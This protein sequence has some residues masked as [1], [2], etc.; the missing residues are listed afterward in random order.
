MLPLF[1]QEPIEYSIPT[2]N[3]QDWS[4]K[5]DYFVAVAKHGNF[6]RI[7]D[8]PSLGDLSSLLDWL[9]LQ[10]ERVKISKVYEYLMDSSEYRASALPRHSLTRLLLHFLLEAPFSA[11]QFFNSASWTVLQDEM[12]EDLSTVAPRLLRNLA[13]SANTM[14]ELILKP[15]QVV[16]RQMK[17]LLLSDFSEIVELIAL[18]ARS[19]EFALDLLL[20]HLQSQTNRLLVG[21]PRAIETFTQQL[22]GVA[23]DHIDEAAES[24]NTHKELLKLKY[25]RESD[26][27]SV[28][29][30]KTRIDAPSGVFLRA[31]DHVRI[32]TASPPQ[33]SPVQQP[34]SLDAIVETAELGAITFRCLQQL[35]PYFEACS[36]KV[37]HCGSFVSSKTMLE[38][39][40]ALH[41]EREDCCKVYKILI[42]QDSADHLQ[43]FP[44][45]VFCRDDLLNESQNKAIAAAMTCPVSLLWGPPGT[46]KTRTVVGI[47]QQLLR[48]EPNKRILVA[49]PT[50]NAVDNILRKFV[51][52]KG[53]SKTGTTPI[54][55]S[56]D[57]SAPLHLVAGADSLAKGPEGVR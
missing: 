32:E 34:L 25:K 18:T 22:Y 50:H 30:S 21:R 38:A 48:A 13:L 41:I 44:Q 36:W 39:T 51:E 35:P 23:L 5:P 53:P 15:F 2:L 33:N 6:D 26:G 10:N 16:L 12:Q 24:R 52:E 42:G 3:D 20:E 11:V 29:E 9:L 55:V 27:F 14:A 46:G 47:L 17:Q 4:S 28:V 43:G 49:A 57:V 45:L 54:R 19:A 31:G 7:N 40:V 1:E 56:T 37:Q 8:I